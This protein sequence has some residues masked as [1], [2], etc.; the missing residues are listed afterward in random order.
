MYLKAYISVL[1]SVAVWVGVVSPANSKIAFH[2]K[3]YGP[4]DACWATSILIIAP[5]TALLGAE[6]VEFSSNNKKALAAAAASH[7]TVP[8]VKDTWDIFAEVCDVTT[9]EVFRVPS[10]SVLSKLAVPSTSMF[11]ETSKLTAST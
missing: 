11:P 3:V 4:L 10:I 9:P 6:I 1:A 7:D 2:A 8:S 5:S